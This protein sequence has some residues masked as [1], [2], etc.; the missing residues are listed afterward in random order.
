[1]SS[2]PRSPTRS[3][4]SSSVAQSRSAHSP[5]RSRGGSSAASAANGTSNA[6]SKKDPISRPGAYSVTQTTSGPAQVLRVQVPQGVRP[7]SEFTVQHARRSVRVRCPITSGPGKTLQITVPPEPIKERKRLIA[8]KLTAA[9]GLGGGGCE[10]M[11][12]EVVKS[13][14]KRMEKYR[15]WQKQQQISSKKEPQTTPTAA[16]PPPLP[17][18][19]EQASKSPKREPPKQIQNSPSSTTKS[20][21]RPKAFLVTIP[22][23]IHPGM[24]FT[25]DVQ[26]KRYVIPCPPDAGPGKKVKIVPPRSRANSSAGNNNN[27]SSTSV[28]NRSRANS[29]ASVNTSNH[30]TAPNRS[31]ADSSSSTGDLEEFSES[32]EMPIQQQPQPSKL[33]MFEVRVPAGVEPG[34]PFALLAN[35]QRVLVTCPPNVQVGQKI[36]FNLPVTAQMVQ[37]IQLQ[38]ENEKGSASGWCRTIRVSDLKFQWVR[39]TKHSGANEDSDESPS[40]LDESRRLLDVN[41][42][43]DFSFR[44][45]AYGRHLTLLK[46][47]D[48]RLRTGILSWVPAKD[49]TVD[50][51]LVLHQKV[52][53]SYADIAA[54]QQKPF[55]DKL[56][57]F[58]ESLS[59]LLLIPW[60]EGHVKMYLRRTYLLQDS[61]DAIMALSRTQLRQRWRLEF[62]N[63]PAVDAGG[64]TREWF[65]LITE[66]IFDPNFGLW[67][68][69]ANNQA[70]ST[71]NPTSEISCPS[72]HLIYFRFLG[73]MMGRALL[74]RQLIHG[75]LVRSLY[76][77]ILGWPITFDDL[78]AQD[79]EYYNSL[80]A[81]T[82]MDEDTLE[83]LCLDFTVTEELFGAHQTIDLVPNGADIDV[84]K[85]NLVEYLEANL[86]YHML[87]H[88]RPQLTELLLGFFDVVPESVLT[89]FDSHELEL[90]LC[91]LP[92]I[93]MEDWEANTK[94]AGHFK[95]LE[96]KHKVV[97]WFWEV[98]RNDFDQEMKA[99]LLQF[100]T[101]TSGVP[102]RG[103]SVLQGN[104]GNIKKFCL[105]GVE[106]GVHTYP[107]A[108]TCFNRL[109]LPLY[110]GKGELRSRLKTAIT[111]SAVGFDMD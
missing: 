14:E 73:R 75:H 38:Y 46:G 72:D 93:D 48:A 111:L 89:V 44:K 54:I 66:Q 110:Q 9:D 52:L 31:R 7:G 55:A 106:G 97:K 90:I 94:Y 92:T 3:R 107:R 33:Q 13:N 91:G 99:R 58:E 24:P 80:H 10:E 87:E 79:E 64:V 98:V 23:D 68:S 69:S 95:D 51:K 81:L 4:P 22:P 101:G 16:P 62:V 86:R 29:A 82:E 21:D 20:S 41:A 74:D 43:N 108:H 103:F 15:E 32:S 8:A 6:A 96:E 34:Q 49:A 17:S 40:T 35:G 27:D 11:T 56:V 37:N 42:M 12:A 45:S 18:I 28:G 63:E 57:W 59:K 47:N 77:H 36:R 71:I 104:D 39:V 88:T 30:S 78:A 53:L 102:S 105:Q 109:D 5:N 19:N 60:E 26:G 65:Q 61:V 84:T 50:S 25:I 67:M 70:C 76:K 100:V 2:A 1:M 85:D 83:A